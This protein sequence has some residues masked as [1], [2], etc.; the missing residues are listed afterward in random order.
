MSKIEIRAH[1][2]KTWPEFFAGIM[3]GT[4]HCEI[5]RN[6]RD[7]RTGDY[8]LLEEWD[9][10]KNAYTK[11]RAARKVTCVLKPGEVP[12]GIEEGYAILCLCYAG[13]G[14]E[15]LLLDTPPSTV[16]VH[17]SEQRG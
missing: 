15:Q 12:S 4:K 13:L 14:Q 2:L 17:W 1:R 7:F 11:R 10:A 5:R 9:P 8:V 3:D 16:D 6:D